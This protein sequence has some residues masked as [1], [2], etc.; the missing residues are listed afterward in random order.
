MTTPTPTVKRDV[1][2]VSVLVWLSKLFAQ[3]RES[4][5]VYPACTCTRLRGLGYFERTPFVA[6]FSIIGDREEQLPLILIG[7]HVRPGND[8]TYKEIDALVATQ[9]AR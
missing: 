4:M 8:I 2:V 9:R 5:H 6:L 3:Q 1:G 7:C